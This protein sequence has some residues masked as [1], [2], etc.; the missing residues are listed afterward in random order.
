MSG[1][2]SERGAGGQTGRRRRAWCVGL[3]YA[4]PVVLLAWLFRDLDPARLA[5]ELAGVRWGA[6]LLSVGLDAL[7]YALQGLRWWFLLG[8]RGRK[9]L[10][11]CV[12]AV[13]CGLFVNS[14]LPLRPGEILRPW[15]VSRETDRSY[16]EVL[17]TVGV[18][19]LLDGFWLFLA[20]GLT[21]A[22]A[23]LP[24]AVVQ[25]ALVL[26]LAVVPAGV[27][28]LCLLARAGAE[29]ERLLSRLPR[30]LRR[31]R[32]AAA[33]ADFLSRA[34]GGLRRTGFSRP[35]WSAGGVSL[36]V[37]AGKIGALWAMTW[38]WGFGLGPL[39]ALALFFI[40]RLGT[41]LPNTPSNVGVY[42]A[43]VV[44]GLSLLGVERQAAARFSLAAF[45]LTTLGVTALAA[46]AFARSGLFSRRKKNN[47]AVGPG[48]IDGR[49]SR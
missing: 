5:G 9:E 37:L 4:V 49:M 17:A 39:A 23:P 12:R 29:P 32:V 10:W 44:F 15:V 14:F 21:A 28:L 22:W 36:A 40:Y 30:R 6:V 31:A 33:A 45:A 46:L 3:G 42:H 34:A 2:A 20:V 18:E 11:L 25:A 13:Y 16:P 35:F 38:A 8:G 48:R 24:G 1:F 19:R 47:P 7:A 27:A 41:A 26:G 43:L